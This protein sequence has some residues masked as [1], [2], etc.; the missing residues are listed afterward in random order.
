MIKFGGAEALDKIYRNYF[1]M[2]FKQNLKKYQYL[3]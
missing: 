2:K 3:F 1:F